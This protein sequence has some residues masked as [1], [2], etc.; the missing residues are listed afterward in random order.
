M[1]LSD[2]GNWTLIGLLAAVVIVVVLAAVYYTGGGM[3]SVKK[4]SPLLDKA[5]TKKTVIGQSMDTGKSVDCRARLSQ[6]RSG[7]AMYKSTSA[8]EAN[9]PNLKDA[10]SNVTA[11]YFQCPVSKQPYIYDPATGTVKCPTH[12][13][14]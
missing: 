6:I 12:P 7:I 13:D 1:R 14:L 5:S 4:G 3:T 11:D 2:R 10:V 8:N 9:P